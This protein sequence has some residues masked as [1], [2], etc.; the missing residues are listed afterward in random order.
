MAIKGSKFILIKNGV[1]LG[2]QQVKLIGILQHS[3]RF[4]VA[5]KLK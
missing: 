2:E 4:N 5:Y 1:N 3:K